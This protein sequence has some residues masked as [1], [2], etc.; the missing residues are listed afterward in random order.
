MCND[1]GLVIAWVKSPTGTIPDEVIAQVNE[2]NHTMST[3]IF[4]VN[5]FFNS[6]D[7]RQGLFYTKYLG[8]LESG[9]YNITIHVKKGTQIFSSATI[10]SNINKSLTLAELYKSSV[11]VRLD[12]NKY[13]FTVNLNGHEYKCIQNM[14]ITI[15]GTNYTM[16]RDKVFGSAMKTISSEGILNQ[17]EG[18]FY[19]LHEFPKVNDIQNVE[20]NFTVVYAD[21]TLFFSG[22]E[23]N[24]YPEEEISILNTAQNTIYYSEN[25]TKEIKIRYYDGLNRPLQGLILN[26][27]GTNISLSTEPEMAE[28][29][30]T[31]ANSFKKPIYSNRTLMSKIGE[32]I[33]PKSVALEYGKYYNIS[34]WY[35]NGTW[36][37]VPLVSEWMPE[38]PTDITEPII[39]YQNLEAKVNGT[40][41]WVSGKIKV[42]S[43]WQGFSISGGN[44]PITLTTGETSSIGTAS[45]ENP[46]DVDYSDGKFFDFNITLWNS[47]R[48]YW[49]NVLLNLSFYY[50]NATIGYGYE[51]NKV[52]NSITIERLP[53]ID[54]KYGTYVAPTKSLIYNVYIKEKTCCGMTTIKNQTEIYDYV[55]FER[56]FNGDKIVFNKTYIF[57]SNVLNRNNQNITFEN[58]S[59]QIHIGGGPLYYFNDPIISTSVLATLE[60]TINA[61]PVSTAE[62]AKVTKDFLTSLTTITY[63]T[64]DGDLS[65]KM[66]TVYDEK[67]LLRSRSY[68]QFLGDTLIYE[69]VTELQMSLMER[70]LEDYLMVLIIGGASLIGIVVVITIIVKK[71]KA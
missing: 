35:S 23:V 36:I 66:K 63:E 13:L 24:L 39:A 47:P 64:K 46:L 37:N 17:L 55:A 2:N 59:K 6:K 9:T 8:P 65:F 67:G 56:A 11:A 12:Q 19:Y 68:Q 61:F 14:I 53:P 70:I 32:W 38:K 21:G 3:G 52:Y 28:L 44:I 31:P 51:F 10:P 29:M 22:D 45:A 62:K 25:I 33:N 69:S 40:H 54:A 34:I 58:N 48:F 5:G 57:D 71:R 16:V 18:D 1:Y 50:G 26:L 42:S 20:F 27:N 7:I 15:N 41:C 4:T 43:F 30:D 49:G 60:E